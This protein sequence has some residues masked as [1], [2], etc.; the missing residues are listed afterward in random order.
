MTF[1]LA[2]LEPALKE[3][4]KLDRTVRDQFKAKLAERLE[5]PRIPSA[6]LHGHPDRYKIKLR[7]AGYRLVYEVRDAEVIVLVIAVGRR[8]RDAVYLAAMKR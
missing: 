1:E 6:K 8:E 2:F 3:W 4:K 5:H 7:G